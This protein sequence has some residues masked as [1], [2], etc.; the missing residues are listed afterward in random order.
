MRTAILMVVG[1]AF[2]ALTAAPSPARAQ[3]VQTL[4]ENINNSGIGREA[5]A[6]GL[7]NIYG[8]NPCAT[9]AAVG[10]TT[11]LFG[12]GGAVSNIDRECETRNNAAV[13]ISGL[14]DMALAREILCGIKDVRE[15]AVRIGKPCLQ[16]MPAQPTASAAPAGAPA[17]PV[18]AVS[19]PAPAVAGNDLRPNAPAFC[20]TPGLAIGLYP[21]CSARPAALPALARRNAR[22]A[23]TM[24]T[25]A[26]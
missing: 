4:N 6:L 21:E 12:I 2:A 23:H 24:T 10:V 14:K 20:H 19:A 8:L 15:A 13:V 16:D 11:P 1:A 5:P 17:T 3:G 18:A 7:S 9:G 22:S 25:A 26:R